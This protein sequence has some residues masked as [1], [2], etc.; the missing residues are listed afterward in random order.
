MRN[1]KR[2]LCLALACIMLIGVMVVGVSAGYDDFTDKDKIV[3]DEAVKTLVNLN[4]IAGKE[5]GSF[6][7]PTGIVTR[8][9][10]AKMI[11]VVLNGG[12]E[13]VIGTQAN[14]TYTDIK[15]HWAEAYIEYCS[16]LGIIA[17]RGNGIFDPNGTVTGTEAAK[18][19]L[20]AM[21]WD[22][23]TFGLVGA[24]WDIT[25][26][27]EANKAGLYEDLEKLNPSNGLTRDDAAQMIYNAIQNKTMQRSW[28]K[29]KTTGEITEIYD[30]IGDP[31]FVD[32]F[33][34]E[35][36]EGLLVASGKYEPFDSA[37]GFS[38]GKNNVCVYVMAVNDETVAKPYDKTLKCTEDV[39]ALIGEYVKVLYDTKGKECYGVYSDSD[40]NTTIL[41]VQEGDISWDNGKIEIDDVKYSFSDTFG[42]AYVCDSDTWTYADKSFFANEYASAAQVKLVDN[43][44]DG[45][46]D[47]GVVVDQVLL[48][49]N[50]VGSDS[51]TI[52]G[53]GSVETKDIT[54]EGT[55]PVKGEKILVTSKAAAYDG[56]Y[57]VAVAETVEGKVTEV[58][59]NSD[60]VATSVKIDGTWYPLY[61]KTELIKDTDGNVI[62]LKNTYKLYLND[63]YAYGAKKITSGGTDLAVVTGLTSNSDFDGYVQ[64]RLLAADGTTIVGYMKPGD[65]SNPVKEDMLVAYEKSGE[66]Y[67]LYPVGEEYA[68][69]DDADKAMAGYDNFDDGDAFEKSGSDRTIVDVKV[70]SNAVIFVQYDKNTG[71]GKDDREWKVISGSDIN[72]WNKSYGDYAQILYNDSGMGFVD[73]AAIWVDDYDVPVPGA[74]SQYA[75]VVSGVTKGTDYVTYQIWDGSGESAV[76]VTEKVSNTVATKGSVIK[77][78]WDDD[79]VV[80]D[81]SVVSENNKG[82]ITANDGTNVKISGNAYVLADDVVILN[83]DTDKVKGVAGDAIAEAQQTDTSKVYYSNAIFQLNS[84]DEIELLVI[85]VVNGMWGDGTP[86]YDDN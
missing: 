34:G 57:V 14:A 76:T 41:N 25:T 65:S 38:A 60:K 50:Y 45:K 61:D 7:D 3:H 67:K 6:F 74:S 15:G 77:F 54:F 46:L 53:R 66:R 73:V 28:S 63:G 21:G 83:V 29:D 22:A 75:Y 11:C 9:E 42:L 68:D 37:Y 49:V 4:V 32:K 35:I 59:Q 79:G 52:N 40:K 85:D 17:G 86:T 71:N 78:V 23:E 62:A 36:Y 5:D 16:N 64:T 39:S 26:N 81:V 33:D 12:V 56:K 31:L 82:A 20:V 27:V 10:M 8:A 72:K 70:N 80:K 13:P 51:L 55:K 18:M 69:A 44:D 58:K 30:L 84:D 1:L 43:D 2:A 47:V 19:L 24:G 48:T